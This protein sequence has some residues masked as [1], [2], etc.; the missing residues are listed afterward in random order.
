MNVEPAEKQLDHK[1]STA[2]A[3]DLKER[4]DH[5]YKIA[6][7]ESNKMA[8][9]HK[10][11]YDRKVRGNRIQVGDKVLV[12]KVAFQSK[13]KLANR[14]ED[15][16]YQVMRQ[17]DPEIPVFDV[18]GTREGKLRTLHRNMLLP[19]HFLPL[20][21]D[22]PIRVEKQDKKEQITGY[23]NLSESSDDSEETPS[24]M[25]RAEYRTREERPQRRQIESE[26]TEGYSEEFLEFLRE[27]LGGNGEQQEDQDTEE[28]QSADED[29]EEQMEKEQDDEQKNMTLPSPAIRNRPKRIRRPPR[30]YCAEMMAQGN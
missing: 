4:L 24:I 25:T 1:T 15:E 19:L 23:F 3:D 2:Y 17:R 5:A 30:R 10:N 27:A 18:K 13:H 6:S 26:N 14:W 21:K 11:I 9:R 28:Q 20:P 22:T 7:E 12:R 8:K 16:V 29:D